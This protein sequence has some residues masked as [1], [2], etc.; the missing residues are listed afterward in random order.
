MTIL[1]TVSVSR[2]K[3]GVA[4]RAVQFALAAHGSDA[5]EATQRVARAVGIF[6]RSI[7]RRGDVKGVLSRMGVEWNADGE[8]FLVQPRVIGIQN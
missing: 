8:G 2:I 6:A 4:A 7:A 1:P 5:D 3:G